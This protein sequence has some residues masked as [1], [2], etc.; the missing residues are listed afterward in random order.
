MSGHQV[1]CW[2][3]ASRTLMPLQQHVDT[4]DVGQQDGQQGTHEVV[5]KVCMEL[6]D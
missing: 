4:H 2:A 5:N 3:A 6:I 1:E